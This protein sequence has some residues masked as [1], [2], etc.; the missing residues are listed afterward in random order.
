[1]VAALEQFIRAGGREAADAEPV[2]SAWLAAALA[3]GVERW[4]DLAPPW[5]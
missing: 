1:M 5:S 3:E 4:P 2:R